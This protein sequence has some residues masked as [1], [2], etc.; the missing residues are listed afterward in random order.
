VKVI[1]NAECIIRNAWAARAVKMLFGRL[2][3]VAACLSLRRQTFAQCFLEVI[4][5][6]REACFIQRGRQRT[7]V[8]G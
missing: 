8:V 5:L 1:G 6:E 4:F 7:A 2:N 3:R